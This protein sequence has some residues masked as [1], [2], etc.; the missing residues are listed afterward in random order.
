MQDGTVSVFECLPLF[1]HAPFPSS[2]RLQVNR[3]AQ[4]SPSDPFLTGSEIQH[5]VPRRTLS[6]HTARA[7]HS[8]KTSW[9]QGDAERAPFLLVIQLTTPCLARAHP[10]RSM[11][12]TRTSSLLQDDPPP[13]YATILSPFVDHTYRVFS[14]HHMQSSHVLHTSLDH[15]RANCTPG[16]VEAGD[17]LPLD[18]SWRRVTTPILTP[19]QNF[20]CVRWFAQRSPS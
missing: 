3:M 11:R 8:L 10:L 7:S 5:R 1:R 9:P 13:A 12:M 20:R 4:R 14:A 15:A 17:R 2:F 19:S 18:A 6:I 16:A